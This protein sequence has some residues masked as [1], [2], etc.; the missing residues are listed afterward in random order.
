MQKKDLY[1]EKL[2]AQLKEWSAAIDVL[3][4]KADKATADLKIGYQ[5]QLDDLKA[6][7]DVARDKINDVKAAGDDAWE[8][9][10]TAMEKAWADIKAAFER[11]KDT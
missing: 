3:K 4:A 11:A 5:K 6:K 1:I 7:R 10:A 8:R 9:M 2:N